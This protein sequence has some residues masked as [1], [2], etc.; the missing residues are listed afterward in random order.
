MAQPTPMP[1]SVSDAGILL[2]G[3]TFDPPHLA[4]VALPVRARDA[5]RPGASLVFVPA[6]RSPHKSAGPA[7]S[8]A[9]RVAMLEAAIDGV[10]DAGVWTD[11][12][13]RAE[14]GEASY[15]VDTVARAR[16]LVGD[17]PVGFVIGSD[18]AVA[19]DRWREARRILELAEPVVLLREPWGSVGELREAI[20]ANGAWSEAEADRLAGAAVDVG[21]IDV[22]ATE[23][24]ELL[25]VDRE[26]ARLES[27]LAPG[28]LRLIRDDG[29]YSSSSSEP[30][31]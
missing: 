12:L 11:E 31:T 13:D 24:R 7:A 14:A 6:A 8:D 9:D 25:A 21:T 17:R 27:L 22:S 20:S 10:A 3:G 4:H 28:V 1:V 16:S 29:L 2:V 26:N 30:R 5:A 15:W 18:Q 19:F 23:I